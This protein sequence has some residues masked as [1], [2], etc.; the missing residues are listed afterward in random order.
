MN[1]QIIGVGKMGSAIAYSLLLMRRGLHIQLYEPL[2]KNI[3]YAYAE[4]L[5]LQPVARITRNDISFW[6]KEHYPCSPDA[7][8]LTAG[9]PRTDTSKPKLA[10]LKPNLAIAKRLTK[11]CHKG[12][13]IFIVTNPPNEIAEALGDNAIPLRDCTDK[14]RAIGGRQFWDTSP[15][16]INEFVLTHKGHTSWTPAYACAHEILKVM[17]YGDD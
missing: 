1:I 2:R 11:D 5:D 16:Q 3:K 4:Y 17:E 13:Y 15:K 8:V 14:L 12:R 6:S 9:K 7:Y 10:L